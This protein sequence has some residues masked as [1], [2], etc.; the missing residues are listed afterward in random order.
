[1]RRATEGEVTNLGD[2][3]SQRVGGEGVETEVN[4][5]VP[6]NRRCF[7][8]PIACGRITSREDVCRHEAGEDG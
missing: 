1:M 8:A 5:K 3:V 4:L 2:V 7:V 6:A